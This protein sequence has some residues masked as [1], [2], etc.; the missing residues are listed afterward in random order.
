M[1]FW[2]WHLFAGIFAP[3]HIEAINFGVGHF[4]AGLFEVIILQKFFLGIS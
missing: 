1:N 2:C 3:N 4:D